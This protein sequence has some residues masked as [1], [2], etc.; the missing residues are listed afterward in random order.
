M[1]PLALPALAVPRGLPDI[2]LRNRSSRRG[3]L[4][5]EVKLMSVSK[6][7]K[8]AFLHVMPHAR[9]LGRRCEKSYVT[10]RRDQTRLKRSPLC[11]ACLTHARAAARAVPSPRAP[12]SCWGDASM[13]DVELT[14]IA[15]MYASKSMC[16]PHFN[17]AGGGRGVKAILNEFSLQAKCELMIR[18][19]MTNENCH[20]N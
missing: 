8:T 12:S 20:K 10:D 4:Q 2:S 18:S 1:W 15:R 11:Q 16:P 14:C 7:A 9:Y 6:Q 19:L 17:M 5:I 3:E 13:V